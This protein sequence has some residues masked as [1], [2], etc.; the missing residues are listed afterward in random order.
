MKIEIKL[1]PDGLDLAKE[2]QDGI[3]VDQMVNGGEGETDS[4]PAATQD[5]DL[6]LE[7][8]QEAIDEYGYGPLNPNLDDTGKNDDFWQ[9]IA[10]TF[11]ADIEAA[12]E[13]RCGNCAAFNLTSRV[14]DCITKGIGM[15]DGADPFESVKAGD[16]GY[17]QFL[18]FKCASMRVCNAWVSGGPIT[19]EKMMAK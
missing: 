1:I 9:S 2:I 17:C 6:N 4:C 16:I 19:D 18:K 15:Y 10:D 3:P 12:K 7:N 8:R 11:N 14:K 13:S 5:I